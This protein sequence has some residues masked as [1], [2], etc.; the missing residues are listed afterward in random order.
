VA[1]SWSYQLHPKIKMNSTN[2]FEFQ[3]DVRFKIPIAM[4]T[5]IM[6]FW[7]VIPFSLADRYQ[8]F[9]GMAVSIYT[10]EGFSF[11]LTMTGLYFYTTHNVLCLCISCII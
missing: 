7:D 1:K 2:I 3:F 5:N 8:H 11:F 6:V 9:R 4:P 10:T